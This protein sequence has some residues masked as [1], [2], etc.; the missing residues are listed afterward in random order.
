MIKFSRIYSDR[1]Q[2]K[3]CREEYWELT[4]SKFE[5]LEDFARFHQTSNIAIE[6]IDGA[7]WVI[8]KILQNNEKVYLRLD[9]QDTRTVPFLLLAEKE[10]EGFQGAVM[11]K[12]FEICTNF[13]DI[14]ANIGFY[15]LYGTRV[16]ETLNVVAFEPNSKVRTSLEVNIRQNDLQRRIEV[17]P[18]ALGSTNQKNEKMYIPK[19]TGTG[20]GSFKKLHPEEENFEIDDVEIMK[21]DTFATLNEYQVDIMK[22]DV[23]GFEM[24]VIQGAINVISTF[25]P[26]IVIELLR[27]WMKPFGYSPQDVVHILLSLGYLCFEIGDKKLNV[28][29]A[30]DDSTVGN[31]FI[32]V[33]SE[34]SRHLQIL[35]NFEC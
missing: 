22:I 12:L 4:R 33:H 23:E 16:S 7:V 21:L 15:S 11:H 9:S 29:K 13:S 6:I 19:F 10:Y 27:K 24:S 25:Q 2:G 20:G 30:I 8:Y 34:N 32:F 28:I 35:Q 26:T 17:I 1:I 5:I 31:N 3:I 14:G 18:L